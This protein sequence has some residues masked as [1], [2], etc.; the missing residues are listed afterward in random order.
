M[1]RSRLIHGTPVSSGLAMGCVHVVRAR[2]QGV[3]EWS[4]APEDVPA[5][6]GRLAQALTLAREKLEHRQ[7]V[8][9]SEAGEKDAEIFAVHRMIL[10]DP[11]ALAEVERTISDQ[12]INAEAA[13]QGLIESYEK[14][15]GGLEGDSVRSFA[16]DFQD[17]WRQVLDTLLDRDRA[18]IQSKGELAV[19]AAADLTPEVVTFLDRERILAVIT[20][21]GGRYSH[22]AVLAN[23]F[24]VPC[25]V[26]LPN[27]LARLEQ[28]MRVTVDGTRGVVQLRPDEADLQQFERRMQALQARRE[29]MIEH[30]SLPAETPDGRVLAIGTNIESV[31]DL[32]FDPSHCDGI[33]LLRTEFLYMERSQFPSEEE[34]YRLYRRVLEHMD[35]YP[36]TMRVLDIGGDKP[37]PYFHCPPEANPALGWRGIRI[38]L[39]WSDLLRVQL[40]ALLRAS[41]LGDLRIL[42]PMISSLEE[43]LEVQRIF[44]G[45]RDDLVQQGYEVAEDV[46]VGLMVEVPSSVLIL[47]Q[48]IEHVDFVSVGTNDLVQYLLAVDRD[49]SW[50]SRL[51]DPQH[52]A[53]L[54][55]LK[56]VA[57]VARRAS[58]PCSVCGELAAD[59]AATILLLGLGYDGVSVA[60]QIV[61]DVKYAVRQTPYAVARE[62]AEAMLAESTADGI[63][64]LY[65]KMRDRLYGRDDGNPARGSSS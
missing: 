24:G 42:L 2:A 4:V 55:A 46:P 12:R 59:P 7:R 23:A 65:M 31:R 53:V 45:V 64:E 48:I 8:V 9:A 1:P 11:S 60:P 51:Y 16:S 41:V 61:P 37:L 57:D 50:V 19:L 49:N 13:V 39:E 58:K 33:G 18:E 10:Q 44:C 26:G 43:V 28:G 35:G 32:T 20:E 38:T 27:L 34:Q 52:P 62:Y 47:P 56:Q 63:R 6:I 17:P 54:L 29:E 22:G 25:V 5:E 15:L 30:A 36:V 21:A 14:K 3:P 40:R